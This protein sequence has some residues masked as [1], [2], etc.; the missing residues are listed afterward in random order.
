MLWS[1][2]KFSA[3]VAVKIM[4]RDIFIPDHLKFNI[5]TKTLDIFLLSI[6]EENILVSPLDLLDI[7]CVH[8]V[9]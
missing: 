9:Y 2:V 5:W 6:Y 3:L 4:K 1:E 7:Y 8:S